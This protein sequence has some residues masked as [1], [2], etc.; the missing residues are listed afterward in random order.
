MA[1]SADPAAFGPQDVVF[2]GLKAHAI[3]DLL[4]GVAKLLGP[5]TMLVPAINGVPWWYFQNEG[6]PHDGLVVRSV[7][8]AGAMHGIVD[9]RSIVGCVVHAAAEV[10]EPGVVHHTSGRGFIVGEIDRALADP[11]DRTITDTGRGAGRRAA[12]RDGLDRH[13]QGRVDQADRQTS[14]SIRWPR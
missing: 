6:G 8:P 2:V 3:P 13:P 7:D 12:R 14:A 11:H 1:A 9:G 5:E 4:P 10:R